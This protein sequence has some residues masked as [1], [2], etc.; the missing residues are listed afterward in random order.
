VRGCEGC[1]L[2][3]GFGEAWQLSPSEEAASNS[4]GVKSTH[5]LAMK[6]HEMRHPTRACFMSSFHTVAVRGRRLLS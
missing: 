6:K 2:V 5:I 3:S 4:D 1:S